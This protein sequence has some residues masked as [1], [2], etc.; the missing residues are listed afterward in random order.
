MRMML[1]DGS[2]RSTLSESIGTEMCVYSNIL[3]KWVKYV[4]HIINTLWYT[5]LT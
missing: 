4:W 2:L 5:R 3:K 1:L